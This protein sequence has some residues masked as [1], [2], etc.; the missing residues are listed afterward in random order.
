MNGC[1]IVLIALVCSIAIEPLILMMLWNWLAPIFW[2]TAPILTFWQ[3]VG[4]CILIN[5]I[6]S[7]FRNI[8]DK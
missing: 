1:I 7:A 2:A 8:N 5:I 3:A 6:G 4:V